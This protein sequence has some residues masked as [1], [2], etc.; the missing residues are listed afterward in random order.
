MGHCA[1]KFSVLQDWRTGHPLYNPI[2]H[3]QKFRRF[4][5]KRQIF[6]TAITDMVNFNLIILIGII[7]IHTDICLSFLYLMAVT[8]LH[9]F[10]FILLCQIFVQR[11]KNAADR[12]FSDTAQKILFLII[13]RSDKFARRTFCSFYN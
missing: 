11:A 3:C 9:I 12:I 4:D 7:C 5:G 6:L 10:Q 13:Y 1:D 2:C 8:D